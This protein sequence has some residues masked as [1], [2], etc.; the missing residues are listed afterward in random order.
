M[1]IKVA[2]FIVSEKSSNICVTANKYV[3]IL[4]LKHQNTLHFKLQNVYIYCFWF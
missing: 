4:Y 3:I 2:A 1:N